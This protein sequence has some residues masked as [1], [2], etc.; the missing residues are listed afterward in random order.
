MR[1]LGLEPDPWQ[2]EVLETDHKRLLL[3]CSRQAGKSTVVALLALAEAI[4]VPFTKVLLLSRSH[5]QSTELFRVVT[6]FFDRLGSPMKKRLNAEELLLNHHSRIICL[7]CKEETIRGYAD[8]SLLVIDEA[9]RVPDDLYRAVRPM[10]ATSN[11]RLIC[12]STPYGK[13]GFFHDCWATGGDDWHRI[14]IPADKVPR[15][16]PDFLTKERRALGESWFR[17][18]YCCSFEALEGL[19]YPDFARCVVPALPA[20]L[21]GPASVPACTSTGHTLVPTHGSLSDIRHP[22]SDIGRFVG[23]IDFGFRNPFAAIWGIIDRDGI[24]WLTGEHYSREKPLSYHAAHLP[25]QVNWYADPA[26][27]GEIAELRCAGFIVRA[28]DNE[29]RPGIAA[30]RARLEDGS[31]RVLEGRCPNLLAEAGLY[32]Y[33]SESE[34]HNSET[35]IDE[36]NHALAALRYLITRLDARRMARIRK[37]TPNTDPTSPAAPPPPQ[38][39]PREHLSIHN[40]TLWTRLF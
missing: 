23:G 28:G 38:P 31:L 40:E 4:F 33:G 24:L 12:L 13:R 32:R 3:N 7:P 19:V 15:I 30:V 1:N 29:R 18:E 10:L 36:H 21:V 35:P 2:I 39:P 25:R 37:P 16:T 9:A 8:I 22:T 14:Q 17:Q 34:G 20:H 11:G 26:G 5:R 27:A 6:G